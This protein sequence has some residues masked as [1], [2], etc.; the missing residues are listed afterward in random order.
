MTTEESNFGAI[1][2]WKN[3]IFNELESNFEESATIPDMSIPLEQLI[4][5]HT[6][7]PRQYYYEDLGDN[8]ITREEFLR[9]DKV[10][11]EQYIQD[12]QNQVQRF[13]LGLEAQREKQRLADQTLLEAARAAQERAPQ[14]TEAADAGKPN[15]SGASDS[16]NLLD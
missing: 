13:K 9:M 1:S 2:T 15:A 5:E 7:D 3:P 10:E 11:R 4:R 6:L 16:T 12:V 8:E 14:A